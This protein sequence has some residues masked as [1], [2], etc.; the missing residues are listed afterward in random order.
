MFPILNASQT[1]P[2]GAQLEAVRELVTGIS[3]VGLDETEPDPN[4]DRTST[5]VR[6]ERGKV[7]MN[8]Y[9]R[10][11]DLLYG[12]FWPDFIL[13]KGLRSR[14]PLD[15]TARRHLLLQFDKRFSSNHQ[16]LFLLANQTQRH[17]H[18]L[19]VYAYVRNHPVAFEAFAKQ[20][21]EDDFMKRLEDAIQNPNAKEV[22]QLLKEMQPWLIGS[23]K[24]VLFSTVARNQDITKLINYTRNFGMPSLFG[25][26]SPDDYQNPQFIRLTLRTFRP[27]AFPAVDEGA[28]INALQ[29]G[30]DSFQTTPFDETVAVGDIKLKNPDLQRRLAENPVLAAEMFNRLLTSVWKILLGVEPIHQGGIGSKKTVACECRARGLFGHMRAAFGATEEQARLSLHHHFLGWTDLTPEKVSAYFPHLMDEVAECLDSMYRAELPAEVHIAQI[31]R[32]A[33]RHPGKRC[34]H[35]ESPMPSDDLFYAYAARTAMHCQFHC[36]SATCRYDF[37]QLALI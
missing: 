30:A 15:V 36:H 9:T 34:V 13:K 1:D 22:I 17:A 12:L 20:V 21:A 10:N 11:D 26:F 27:D 29:S 14:G 19:G 7:P 25:T 4:S 2:S 6:V 37:E 16:L 18:N 23:S 3:N 8:E 5:T 28:L 33:I 32:Q 35:Y 24:N 31:L